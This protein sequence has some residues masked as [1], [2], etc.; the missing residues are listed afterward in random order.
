MT[1]DDFAPLVGRTFALAGGHERL[2][3]VAVERG[4]TPPRGGLPQPFVLLFEGPRD[5]VLPEGIY[6]FEVD[7]GG[8]FAFHIMPIMTSPGE[9]QDYQAVFN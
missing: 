7:G 8:G 2:T 9:L 5:R 3:L 4:R 6:R 1:A